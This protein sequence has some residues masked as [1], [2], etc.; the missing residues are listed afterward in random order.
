MFYFDDE[1]EL[2]EENGG[3]IDRT[4]YLQN[5]S[6][7]PNMGAIAE[8]LVKGQLTAPAQPVSG[9]KFDMTTGNRFRYHEKENGNF[10]RTPNG[11]V[12]GK[13]NI[14]R[15]KPY[16]VS[17]YPDEFSA[18]KG[19]IVPQHFPVD[20]S[21]IFARAISNARPFD[22]LDIQLSKQAI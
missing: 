10:L 6:H 15:V 2:F 14:F 13:Q 20:R 9:G 4:T 16:I 11:Q 18:G 12:H 8:Y 7:M 21:R 22:F 5:G 3:R 1:A 17:R 19:A